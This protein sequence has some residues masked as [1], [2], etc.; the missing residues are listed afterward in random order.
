[1]DA[2][3]YQVLAFLMFSAFA[4]FAVFFAFFIYKVIEFVFA[5]IKLYEK[6]INRQDAMLALLTQIKLILSEQSITKPD[7]NLI[8]NSHKLN[9]INPPPIPKFP[10][11]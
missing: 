6:I 9:N 11:S 1:M 5:A 4:V 2:E 3:G 10:S 8:E 7:S